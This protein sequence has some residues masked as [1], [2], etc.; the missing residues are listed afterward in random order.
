LDAETKRQKWYFK[1]ANAR[2]DQKPGIEWREI[3][4]ETPYLAS[5]R[6]RAVC[7]DRMVEALGHKLATHHPVIEP[8]SAA[9]P[10]TKKFAMQRRAPKNR[11]HS[12]RAQLT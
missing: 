10:G 3:P 12:V 11:L 2:R 5:Y 9:E 4:A 7:G 1:R 6:K 8:V